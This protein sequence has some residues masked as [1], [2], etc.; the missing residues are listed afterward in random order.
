MDIHT[1]YGV[2]IFGYTCHSHACVMIIITKNPYKA[3]QLARVR[4]RKRMVCG[5]PT[6]LMELVTPVTCIAT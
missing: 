4:M 2:C 5:S 6:L 1:Y 3:M